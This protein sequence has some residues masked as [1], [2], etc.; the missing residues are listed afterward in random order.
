MAF[1]DLDDFFDDAL[2]LPIGG[3]TYVITISAKAGLRFQRAFG[4]VM[5]ANAGAQLTAEDLAS[6]ELD[7]D[8]EK[9][10][11]TGVLGPVYQ[12]MLDDGLS[13]PKI[14]HAAMTAFMYA[15]GDKALAEQ[16]WNN[17]GAVDAAGKAPKRPADRKAKKSSATK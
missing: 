2:R 10:L 9:D 16:V 7:D 17:P 13:W 3:K 1:K 4:L 12:E 5:A 15:A 14:R 8:D 11:F 6:L